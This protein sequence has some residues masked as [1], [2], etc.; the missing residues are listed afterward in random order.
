M[1][2]SIT[3]ILLIIFLISCKSTKIQP[4][5]RIEWR[6]KGRVQECDYAK[7]FQIINYCCILYTNIIGQE[8]VRCGDFEVT[9]IR[10]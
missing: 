4:N 6:V 9:Q 7:D 10:K 8:V 2:K 3:I 1:G 5:Y